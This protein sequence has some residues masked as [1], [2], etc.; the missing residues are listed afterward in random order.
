[1]KSNEHSLKKTSRYEDQHQFIIKPKSLNI[2][3][4]T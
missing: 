4:L 1:M 2:L 3:S